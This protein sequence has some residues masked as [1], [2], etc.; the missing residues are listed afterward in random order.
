MAG[1]DLV[2]DQLLA[3]G[4]SN[5]EFERQ[6]HDICIGR[7]LD[8]AVGFATTLGP[9]GEALRLAGAGAETIRPQVEAALREALGVFVKND[10]VWAPSSTWFI[11]ATA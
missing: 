8:E 9:A 10:G 1:A 3:A 6:E 7:D 11:R 4:Y 5:I 2:S